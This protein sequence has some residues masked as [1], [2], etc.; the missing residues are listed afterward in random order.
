MGVGSRRQ[1][2]QWITE[3]RLTLKGH[4]IALGTKSDQLDAVW[5]DGKPI[6]IHKPKIALP[7]VL[8]YYKPDGEV[9]TR[10]DPENR[11]T[12]FN[13]LPPLKGQ[14]WIM[15]GRLDL[16]T[17]GLLLF[18]TDGELSHRLLHPAYTIEREYAVRVMGRV[19][20]H[21]LERLKKGVH[22]S[23]GWAAFT[24]ITDQGGTGINHWYNVTL[25][26]GRTHEVRRLWESQDCKVS[27]LIRIRF[28][29]ITLPQN[30][31]KGQYRLLEPLEVRQLA[32]RVNLK[33]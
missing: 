6:S 32:A 12:V 23:D 15:V 14:R 28:D 33:Y 8:L 7:Q 1:I 30:L 3:G 26:E 10:T 13:R 11:L 29:A 24:N 27:R 22:L 20:K 31:S 5:L 21:T 18:T 16:P 4:Q 2:E 19:N 25:K 17:S 9:C